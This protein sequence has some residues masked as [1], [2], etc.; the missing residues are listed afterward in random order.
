MGAKVIDNYKLPDRSTV[1][2]S[3]IVLIMLGLLVFAVVKTR[4]AD[5]E[6]A[7]LDGKLEVAKGNSAAAEKERKE[8]LEWTSDALAAARRV[9][10]KET[11][12]QDE[13]RKRISNL[14][15]ENQRLKREEAEH[16]ERLHNETSK[17]AT[18]KDDEL[19]E[20][21]VTS[22]SQAY[23]TSSSPEQIYDIRPIGSMGGT[24]ALNRPVLESMLK[25]T[26]EVLFSRVLIAKKDEQILV[27]QEKSRTFEELSISLAVSGERGYGQI[28][29][30]KA[31][32]AE[33]WKKA[34]D[35]AEEERDIYQAQVAAFRKS[36]RWNMLKDGLILVGIGIGAYAIGG[37]K[38]AT[39]A[40]GAGT[41]FVLQKTF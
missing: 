22:L 26:N 37:E 39:F 11:K 19:A 23:P 20:S 8:T 29:D 1:I 31:R 12:V 17:I 14:D 18:Y 21:T 30:A 24:F 35:L 6:I 36:G 13:L 16:T 5:R 15:R 2:L 7:K 34:F 40:A 32:E 10:D 4:T 25:V 33:Q 27:W 3:G 9:I 41:L 28:A 38:G